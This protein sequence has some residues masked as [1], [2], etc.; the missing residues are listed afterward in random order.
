M[1]LDGDFDGVVCAGFCY[2][3]CFGDLG[4]WEMVSDEGFHVDLAG[5]N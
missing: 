3:E 5:G 4:E 2:F 1:D